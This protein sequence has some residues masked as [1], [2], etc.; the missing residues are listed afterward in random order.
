[1]KKRAILIFYIVVMSLALVSCQGAGEETFY[2]INDQA[3]GG[4][5]APE[6]GMN[7]KDI[8]ISYFQNQTE[9]ALHIIYGSREETQSEAIVTDLPKYEVSLL[10][11]PYRLAVRLYGIDYVDYI[12]KS[13]WALDE[14]VAGVFR[15]RIA[16]QDYITVYF[17]LNARVKFRVDE[18]DGKI[19]IILETDKSEPENNHFVMLNAFDE[20]LEGAFSDEFG[21]TPVLCADRQ[22]IA[23]ISQPYKTAQEADAKLAQLNALI[24]TSPISKTPY[25]MTLAGEALPV[26]NLDIDQF[27]PADKKMVMQ[28]DVATVLPLLFENG[29]YAAENGQTILFIKPYTPDAGEPAIDG[30]SL[31]LLTNGDKK[32]QLNLPPFTSIQ[33]AAFSSD[34]RYIAF[35]DVT[36]G[37]RVLY[38]FDQETGYLYNLGEEGIGNITASFAWA[39]D[40][41]ALYAVTGDESLRLVRCAFIEGALDV[42]IISEDVSSEGK[43]ADFNGAVIYAD[44]FAGE[45]GII[46]RIDKITGEKTFLT[47]GVDFKIAPDGSGMAVTEYNDY[48]E[49]QA[50]VN[51][52]IYSF[53]DRSETVIV[54]GGIVES[55]AFLPSSNTVVYSDGTQSDY[56]YRFLYALESYDLSSGEI[57]TLTQMATGTFFLSQDSAD[58]Y[59]IDYYLGDDGHYHYTTYTYTLS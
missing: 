4:V 12:E 42:Q 33:V 1:M 41:H 22:N 38:V 36:V 46:Y 53:A 52:K 10:D 9:I 7:I 21:L 14:H 47:E 25:T 15:E 31:W 49:E 50:Y 16:N 5:I 32:T 39:E 45:H 3:S 26:I 18:G 55:F 20:Y 57:T 59:L 48:G 27:V 24:Q 44:N 30:E 35:I 8:D 28:N 29:R 40:G 6:Q 11:E 58:C 2:D 23:M 34:G 37:S 51:L 43:I 56:T 54:D 13:S 19:R 17:Q